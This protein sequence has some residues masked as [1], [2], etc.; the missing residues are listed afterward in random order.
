MLLLLLVKELV[1]LNI[2]DGEDTI[3]QLL[4]K[5]V[6]FLKEA[7][8]VYHS[9]M[10][11]CSAA[12]TNQVTLISYLKVDLS[13]PSYNRLYWILTLTLLYYMLSDRYLK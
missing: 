7:L 2:V 10:N 12:P 3:P 4:F 6:C 5:E 1:L 13:L 11:D 8:W 9:G